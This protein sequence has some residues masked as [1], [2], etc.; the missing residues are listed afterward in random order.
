MIPQEIQDKLPQIRELCKAHDVQYMYLFGSAARGEMKENSDY[1]F[2]MKIDVVSEDYKRYSSNLFSIYDK[3]EK[4]FDRKIDVVTTL[5]N[6]NKYF[7]QSID[8]TKQK[9]Y[10]G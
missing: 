2:Y 8:R 6:P 4:L 7:M 10:E 3:L 5:M 9:L 1:D